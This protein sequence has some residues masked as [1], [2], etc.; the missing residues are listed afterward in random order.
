VQSGV[1]PFTLWDGVDWV[2]TTS[3]GRQ[4]ARAD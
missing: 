2:M 3:G 1:R 4:A